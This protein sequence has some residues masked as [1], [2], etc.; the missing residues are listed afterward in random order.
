MVLNPRIAPLGAPGVLASRLILGYPMPPQVQG[1]VQSAERTQE[2]GDPR[3]P[4]R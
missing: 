3:K 1:S 2:R 4:R